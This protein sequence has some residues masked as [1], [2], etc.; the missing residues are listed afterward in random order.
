[1][2][3]ILIILALIWIVFA[4]VQ[5]FKYREIANW[6][7]FSLIIFALAIRLFYSIF[8]NNYNYV[9]FGLAGLGVFF[10]LAYG[11][12]YMRLFAGGDAKLHIIKPIS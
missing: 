2:V 7:S 1:M 6:L 10:I 12:Y 8:S 9:L 3:I 11:F 4:V 5:D